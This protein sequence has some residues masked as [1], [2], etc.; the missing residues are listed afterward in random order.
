MGNALTTKSV[1]VIVLHYSDVALTRACIQSL[2]AQTHPN[3][4]IILIDNGSADK[5]GEVLR[6]EFDSIQIVTLED[7]LGFSGGNNVGMYIALA[8]ELDYVVLINNDASAQPNFITEVLRVFEAHPNAG[9]VAPVITYHDQPGLIWYGGGKLNPTFFFTR[10]AHMGKSFHPEQHPTVTTT[11]Y[12]T[13]CALTIRTD[14]LAEVGPFWDELFL[15]FEDTDLSLRTRRAGYDCLLLWKPLVRHHISASSGK[16]GSNKLSPF[17]AYY[18]ARNPMLL[19]RIRQKGLDTVTGLLGQF[20]IR[21]GRYAY[22]ALLSGSYDALKRYLLGMYA[23]LTQSIDAHPFHDD[24]ARAI[25]E[26]Y[27]HSTHIPTAS[28][29]EG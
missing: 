1:G 12:V 7:N 10:H 21:L 25:A 2:L 23:G 19:I 27:L 15:Y 3:T 24:Q 28:V 29:R 18:F 20:T 14:V 4:H 26:D 17:M 13:G 11:D 6:P 16:R 5:A 22:Q 9:I 8:Q